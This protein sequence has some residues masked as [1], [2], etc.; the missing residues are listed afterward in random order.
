MFKFRSPFSANCLPPDFTVC[1]RAASSPL[2]PK[3]R[4]FAVALQN[5]RG[6]RI[7][8]SLFYCFG[9][10][11]CCASL[12]AEVNNGFW[13]LST[14]TGCLRTCFNHRCHSVC[15]GV[16]A[17]TRFSV[18]VLRVSSS[19]PQ[20]KKTNEIHAKQTVIKTT[21]ACETIPK[22]NDCDV[23]QVLYW[24]NGATA[25]LRRGIRACRFHA[26][27]KRADR[28]QSEETGREGD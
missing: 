25:V 13:C 1:N 15:V 4:W 12:P 14:N 2:P 7:C 6:L 16:R 9:L 5:F 18:R 21:F 19:P 27:N 11:K 17:V 10:N 26:E 3:T 28:K 24:L 23:F 8:S 22:T 20:N